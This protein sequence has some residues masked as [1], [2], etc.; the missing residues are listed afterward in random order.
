[1]KNLN[2]S[3]KEILNRLSVLRTERN[4][5]AYKLSMDLGHAKTYIYR[6]ESGE[7][8]LSLGGVLRF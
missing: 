1:M 2:L 6:I 3:K 4:I 5:S 7:I 8:Q